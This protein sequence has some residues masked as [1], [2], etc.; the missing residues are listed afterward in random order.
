MAR[1]EQLV[2]HYKPSILVTYLPHA[3]LFGRIMGKLLGIPTVICSIRVKLWASTKYFPYFLLDG[4]TSPLVT[5]YHANSQTVARVYR[6]T[7][8]I[9]KHKMT[10]IANGI[11]MSSYTKSRDTSQLKKELNIPDGK[12]IIG[13]IARL[14]KQKGHTYLI[15]AFKEIRKR[16]SDVV[17]I[18]SGDGPERKNIEKEIRHYN[19]QK[20]ILMLGHRDDIP[21]ILKLINIFIMPT[22]FEGMSNS[23]LEAMATGKA[24]ITTNIAENRELIAPNITGLL[25]PP[26]KSHAII[27][28]LT[29]LLD[30]PITRSVLGKA[31]QQEAYKKYQLDSIINQYMALY[32]SA[33]NLRR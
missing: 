25:I 33:H 28:S 15:K 8:F 4:L 9:P 3:D 17:L 10:Y 20:H 23:I 29:A 13:C 31:A 7:F 27:Q 30:S 21:T 26:R 22:L 24:I 19:M 16:R 18:I 12:I 1:F 5:H 2:R 32:S 11:T 6:K 14:R